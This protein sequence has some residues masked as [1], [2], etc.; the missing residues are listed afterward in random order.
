MQLCCKSLQNTQRGERRFLCRLLLKKVLRIQFFLLDN[1]QGLLQEHFYWGNISCHLPTFFAGN[2]AWSSLILSFRRANWFHSFARHQNIL[3][4]VVEGHFTFSIPK[5][6]CDLSMN[7]NHSYPFWI[8]KL[9][10]QD[11]FHEQENSN[12][13]LRPDLKK[14]KKE[15]IKSPLSLSR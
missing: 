4:P 5:L 12:L 15:K 1:V 2:A 11:M 6:S 8:I 14:K 9:V 13:G 3:P 10:K 7:M